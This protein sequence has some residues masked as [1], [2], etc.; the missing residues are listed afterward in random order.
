MQ[1]GQKCR[2]IQRRKTR[3]KMHFF[4]DLKIVI[5]GT[6]LVCFLH[7]LKKGILQDT[8]E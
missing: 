1:Q 3:Y 4:E 2:S 7:V 5:L 6:V 8:Q